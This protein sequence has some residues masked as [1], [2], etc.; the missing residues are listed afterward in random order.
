MTAGPTSALTQQAGIMS[1]ASTQVYV[2][3]D[4]HLHPVTI[5]HYLQDLGSF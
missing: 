1:Q 5:E 2:D 4:T 3:G